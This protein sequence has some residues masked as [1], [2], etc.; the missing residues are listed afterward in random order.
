[1]R[2]LP[3]G[4]SVYQTVALGV[5]RYQDIVPEPIT[6]PAVAAPSVH[7]GFPLW[8]FDHD[9][10]DLVAEVIFGEWGIGR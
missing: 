10:A 3:G 5:T 9:S 6:G 4:F 2:Q 8:F 7:M 1:M